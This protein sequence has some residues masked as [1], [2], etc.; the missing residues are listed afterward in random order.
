MNEQ[1]RKEQAQIKQ[2]DAADRKSGLEKPLSEKTS[3]DFAKY[4]ETT[5]EPPNLNKARKRGRDKVNVHYDFAIPED[6]ENIGEGK[7]SSS[8]HTVVK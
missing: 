3:A 8:V 6:M 5:Y 1:Q 7:N 2:V 4:F